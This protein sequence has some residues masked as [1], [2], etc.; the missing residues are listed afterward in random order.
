MCETEKRCEDWKHQLFAM[1]KSICIYSIIPLPPY[2][3]GSACTGAVKVSVASRMA[4]VILSNSSRA[5]LYPTVRIRCAPTLSWIGRPTLTRGISRALAMYLPLE[6]PIRIS[7]LQLLTASL[8]LSKSIPSRTT[9][10]EFRSYLFEYLHDPHSKV[11]AF[12]SGGY[13]HWIHSK[14]EHEMS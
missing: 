4:F 5:P 7:G 1:F 12:A 6:F 13:Q 8:R 3:T 2:A 11:P 10:A 14:F 9:G